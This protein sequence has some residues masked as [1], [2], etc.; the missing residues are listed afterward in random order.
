MTPEELRNRL[1]EKRGFAD[2][3]KDS[4]LFP[5]YDKDL[6][7]V[8][9]LHDMDRACLRIFKAILT[10]ETIGIY[11]DYDADGIPGSVVLSDALQTLGVEPKVYIPH[12]H[13]EGYG[14]HT[15]AIDELVKQGVKLIITVDVGITE[16]DSINHA[17]SVG[18]DV[19]VTDHHEPKEE[20]PK[21]HAIVHPKLPSDTG[22]PYNDTMICGCAVAFRLVTALFEKAREIKH[23]KAPQAGY[24]KWYLDLVGIATLSDMVPL[25]KESRVLAK[26]GLHVLSKTKRPGLL[27]LFRLTG[28][29]PSSMTEDDVVFSITP[30]INA[31]SRMGHPIQA[32]NLLAAKSSYEADKLARDLDNLNKERKSVTARIMKSV[33]QMMKEREKRSVIVI[34]DPDWNIGVL[35]IVATSIIETYKAPAFVW[36]RD[37]G[38]VIKGSCRGLPGMSVVTLMSAHKE[39]FTYFGG[40]AGAGGFST[41]TEHI[42]ELEAS[43]HET[44]KDMPR[45][46]IPSDISYDMELSLRDVTQ[47]HWRAI[48]ELAPFG[49]GNPKPVFKWN[50]TVSD[51]RSFGKQKEHLEIIVTDASGDRVSAKSFYTTPA[52]YE[53]ELAPGQ[54]I[55]LYGTMDYSVFMR[56]GTLCIRIVDIKPVA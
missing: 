54:E 42:H 49:E 2:E 46:E 24:E 15:E 55:I 23:P 31:A 34:G 10:G 13:D 17:E 50:V 8:W 7:S 4:F 40:H 28:I 21:A 36:S 27:S 30:K 14:F 48:R 16:I 3:T 38:G 18:V 5:S 22:E 56:Q 9:T 39:R 44:F 35:G 32:F 47:N 33:H 41:T 11:A 45:G 25:T 26:W 52:S 1:L 51:V 20:L 19:I 43:L 37:Q 12:R 53:V 29:D 6:S